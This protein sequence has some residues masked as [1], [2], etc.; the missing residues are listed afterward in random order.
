[1]AAKVYCWVSFGMGGAGLDPT[2]GERYLVERLKAIGVDT[3]DSPYQWS[4][5][6]KIYDDEDTGDRN[7]LRRRR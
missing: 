7:P 5:L 4:D 2:Y 3:L 1:M 6:Q